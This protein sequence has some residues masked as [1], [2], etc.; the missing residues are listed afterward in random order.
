MFMFKERSDPV[1]PWQH[2]QFYV[3]HILLMD[4]IKI[5]VNTLFT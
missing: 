5:N 4:H 2:C 3:N 1:F